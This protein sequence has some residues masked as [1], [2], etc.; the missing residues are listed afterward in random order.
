MRI[1][2][3]TQYYPPHTGGLEY[4][5]QKTAASA[6]A[7]GH[8]VEVVTYALDRASRGE[9][10]EGAVSVK[11][12]PGLHFI[13][14]YFGVPFALGGLTMVRTI[15][16]SVRS[17]DIVHL[18]DVFYLTSLVTYLAVR[19]YK[20][21]LVLSQ[22]VA[23]V[24]HTSRLIMLIERVVYAL[25][26]TRIFH[27]SMRIITY[28]PV[29]RDF[30]V[31]Q[32]IPE[33]K[34]LSTHNGIDL[35]RFHTISAE[36]KTARRARL[37]LPVDKTLVL[38]VG[39]L[40][41]KKGYKELFE[42]RDSA[43]DLVFVGPGTVQEGWKHASGVHVLGPRTPEELADLYPAMDIL[44]AP[45]TGEMFTVV[46]Q[47]AFACGL[48]VL[49][50]DVPEYRA[51]D[52]DRERIV[53]CEPTPEALKANLRHITK[54]D[55]LRARMAEYSRELAEEL[56]DWNKNVHAVLELYDEI[57]KRTPHVY[58]T[59][60]WDD[61]HVLD[62][63]LATLLKRYGVT[64]TFYV[65]PEN[66]EVPVEQRLTEEQIRT[67]AQDF[68]IGAHTL[69]HQHL[70]TLTDKEAEREI[71]DSKTTLEDITGAPVTSFCYPAGKYRTEHVRM[72][73]DSGYTLARTVRRFALTPVQHPFEMETSVHTYDHWLDVWNLA[74]SVHCNPFTF[75]RLYRKWD[76]QA[77][78]LFDQARERGGVF[79]LWG[80]SWELDDRDGWERL[81][82]VL[83]YIN[84]ARNTRHV[85]N[86]ALV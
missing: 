10:M 11:R 78:A 70:P 26:G 27:A 23:L 63:K 13:D 47:E 40:V 65:A 80:H 12:V 83:Q 86:K 28:Q 62:M 18:H 59:T 20:K 6:A 14:R 58:V 36:E 29:V 44:A 31:Q 39:R 71:R 32:G 53:L 57:H 30:L 2:Y 50:T 66:I 64:G 7:A 85:P 82:R 15:M 79:H 54:D 67:L 34:I 24:E 33:T 81:E 51:Y 25:W 84:S 77:I 8:D 35:Q 74:C 3:I 56:F 52:L 61:G 73:A 37:G 19:R 46:M 5:A 69:T 1:T 60:S 17:A 48:P 72:V 75:L 38:F 68:E 55:D 76:A 16:R 42:A 4:V 45:S 9:S 49:A 21:P 43:Y 22:H 41:P